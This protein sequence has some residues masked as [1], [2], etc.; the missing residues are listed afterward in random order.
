MPPL[1]IGLV[2][3]QE[4]V[5]G[6]YSVL[7]TNISPTL[8]IYFAGLHCQITRMMCT[9]PVL[10]Q[11]LYTIFQPILISFLYNCTVYH[12]PSPLHD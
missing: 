6:M 4:Y 12:G 10:T 5:P 11:L 9:I 7:Y 1:A 3:I 8:N 2:W